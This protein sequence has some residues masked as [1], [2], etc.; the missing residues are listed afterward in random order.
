MFGYAA[1]EGKFSFPELGR[2]ETISSNKHTL[3][4]LLLPHSVCLGIDFCT[5]THPPCRAY[6]LFLY[7]Y[8]ILCP[9]KIIGWPL[10]LI[11]IAQNICVGGLYTF[12]TLHQFFFLNV[13][14]SWRVCEIFWVLS[15]TSV[16]R[17]LTCESH[18]AR[19]FLHHAF[20]L[21]RLKHLLPSSH[22]PVRC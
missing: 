22:F 8:H 3:E 9:D 11:I 18:P 1:L 13:S 19:C 15:T 14:F 6:V 16:N 7:S 10:W 5:W 21:A 20:S 2:K 17:M 12:V 4:L